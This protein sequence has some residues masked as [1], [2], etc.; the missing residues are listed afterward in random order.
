MSFNLDDLVILNEKL[1]DILSSLDNNKPS[2]NSCFDFLNYFRNN[3]EIFQN[4]QLLIKNEDDYIII[5][6]S[7]N[8]ILISIILLYDYSYKQSLLNKI[9][10]FLKE[11]IN[12]NYQNLIVI[13]EYLLNNTLL[14]QIKNI[15][16]LKLLQIISNAKYIKENNNSFDNSIS[17]IEI[18]NNGNENEKQLITLKNNT[19]F[20]FQTIKIIIKN[21]KNKN[22]HVLLYFFKEIHKKLSLKD[23]FYFFKNKIL[24]SNGLFGYMSPQ[25]VLKQSH[26]SFNTI[27]PPYIKSISK[28]KY[29]LILGLEETLINFKFGSSNNNGIS[30]ILRFRPGVNYFLS[31]I[32]KY[33]E[34]IAFSLYPQKIGDYLINALE[35]KE[36]YFDYRFFVQHCIIVEN[37]FVKDLKRIGRPLDKIIIVD[38]L[39]QNY[40]LNK[41]NGINIKSYWDEDY[42]DVA[43][44]E[45]LKILI[46]IAHEGGDVRDGIEKY[47]N[48]ILGKVSSKVD[49]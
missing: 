47:R 18:N 40:K 29:T 13:Y 3:C 41:K 15:W 42:N 44:G 27:N 46:N 45:L 35:K 10:Y 31:E 38:N 43:L 1:K 6:N 11:M 30:G 21:Y 48:E 33:F 7:I 5:K 2:Y 8:Y 19:S 23:I 9:I 32:K 26:N 4:L 12:F 17:N 24:H 14:S 25:L 16:E 28:K 36:K 37:E 34:I 49:L 39:P 20:I 22:S